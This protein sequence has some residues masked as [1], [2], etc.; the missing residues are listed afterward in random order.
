MTPP[1]DGQRPSNNTFHN[2]ASN[3]GMQGTARDVTIN[4]YHD[5]PVPP[6]PSTLTPRQRMELLDRLALRYRELLDHALAH[7]VRL[8]LD[9]HTRPDA[10]DPAW[11]HMLLRG[12]LTSQLVPLGTPVLELFD[13]QQ[14][15]L[16]VLGAPGAG[17]TTLIVE[18]A[19]ALT[20]R[21]LADAQAR[22]PVVLNIAAWRS[23]QSLRDW[24]Q[25]ALRDV[26]GA[27]RRFAVQ[28]AGSDDLLLL[29]D[30]L[31]EVAAEHRTACVAAI[32]AYLGER[33]LA[34]P[35]VVGCR[36]R[37]YAD[38]GIQLPIAGAVEL[39]PLE[40]QAIERAL[41][42]V[43]AA[44]GVLVALQ[45]DE[46]LRELAMTPLMVN[47]LLLGHGGQEV[48][49]VEAGTL[50]ERRRVLWWAY[51]RRMLVQRPLKIWRVQ[52]T[53]RWMR[54]LSRML[55]EQSTTDFLLD[56]LQ[57][58]V[59]SKRIFLFCYK[60][61]IW[62]VFSFLG[63]LLY[64]L[65][66]SVLM[67]VCFGVVLMYLY[68]TDDNIKWIQYGVEIWAIKGVLISYAVAPIVGLIVSFRT[69]ISRVE[70]LS[71]RGIPHRLEIIRQTWNWVWKIS[72]IFG[73]S[74]IVTELPIYSSI[75][76]WQ[77]AFMLAWDSFLKVGIFGIFVGVLISLVA[78]FWHYQ[79]ISRQSTPMQG[80][81]PS[82]VLGIV[83]S[84]ISSLLG[85]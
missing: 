84:I 49:A 43:S 73:L 60:L 14:G 57:P 33:D 23:G 13:G 50:E 39:E 32:S 30:G 67:G 4:H 44:A 17:K 77:D 70:R 11:R 19:Q 28:L 3:Y 66:I 16:L 40:L 56:N 64:G 15:Q 35:L 53:F 1:P 45:T 55:R 36:S 85:V 58:S 2:H 83:Q 61:T 54:W 9:L 24:L 22:I 80:F 31:D 37:E 5:A 59:L 63:G 7:Q 10:V 52:Q 51:V 20:V 38:L 76:M 47:V 48:P 79:P 29:L 71:W 75:Y 65:L 18:L 46:L 6:T 12:P 78:L 25:G 72:I 81:V 26:L 21:A 41:E 27:S 62:A 68:P 8:Q 82:L 34:P 69:S 74:A 42:G